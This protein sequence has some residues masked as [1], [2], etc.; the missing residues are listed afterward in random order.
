MRTATGYLETVS[1]DLVS[2]NSDG[3]ERTL[4]HTTIQHEMQEW[5]YCEIQE[6]EQNGSKIQL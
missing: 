1:D 4:G 2:E 5:H 6:N 3:M